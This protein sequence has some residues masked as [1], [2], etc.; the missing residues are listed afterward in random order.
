MTFDLADTT[1]QIIDSRPAW[2]LDDLAEAVDKATPAVTRRVA[3]R[4]A[5]REYVRTA[6]TG[7]ARRPPDTAPTGQSK[8][9]TQVEGVGEGG[10]NLAASRVALFRAGYRAKVHAGPGTWKDLTDCTA[11]ELDFAAAENERMA[12]ANAAAAQRY[13][14]LAKAMRAAN[15]ATVADL[16]PALL[17]GLAA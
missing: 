11:D 9:D 17:E 10:P 8:P 1:R 5:L 6:M 15:A 14:Q 13:R 3:Y 2:T 4:D 12:E 7:H 16:D